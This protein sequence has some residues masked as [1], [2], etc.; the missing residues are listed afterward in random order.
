MA[1]FPRRLTCF[2]FTA[3]M[4][5]GF[6]AP[7]L[8]QEQYVLQVPGRADLTS[9]ATVRGQQLAITDSANQTFVYERV[10]NLDTADGR[11]LGFYSRAAGQALRWPANGAGSMLIG[12]ANGQ[13]WR[14][15]R[16]QIRAQQP[17]PQR[18]LPQPVPPQ[19]PNTITTRRPN[20]DRRMNNPPFDNPQLGNQG[21]NVRGQQRRQQLPMQ[22]AYT[23][24]GDQALD[25]GYIGP[26]G[27]LQLYRGWRDKWQPQQIGNAQALQSAGLIPGAPL[28]LVSRQGQNVPSAFTVNSNGRLMEIGSNGRVRQVANDVQF[29]PRSHFR[30]EPTNNGLNGFAVDAQGRLWNLDLVSGRNQ[31]IDQNVDRFTPGSPVSFLSQPAARGLQDDLFL[32][33]RTGQLVNYSSR[34][35]RWIGPTS[36]ASG[37][38]AGAPIAATLQQ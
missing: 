19:G 24:A 5:V 14:Q 18:P 4:G 6:F 11:Y 21:A 15:S 32:V 26:K 28:Q 1:H 8:A 13:N 35:G 17:V 10:P 20:Y 34:G 12:D 23:R 9:T 3:L 25:V 33:D 29:A 16:Q 2:M 30:I 22:V 38:P 37:F 36:V 27:D 7:S 31:L